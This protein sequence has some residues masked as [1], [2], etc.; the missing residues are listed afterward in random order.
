VPGVDGR[1][2]RVVLASFIGY[3]PDREDIFVW[4]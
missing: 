3:S 1:E 4:S 2:P